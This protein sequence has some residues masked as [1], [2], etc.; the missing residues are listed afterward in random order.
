MYRPGVDFVNTILHYFL[1]IF[2]NYQFMTKRS[3]RILTEAAESAVESLKKT[4]GPRSLKRIISAGVLALNDLTAEEREYYCAL[5]A[6]EKTG[7]RPSED[8]FRRKVVQ[9]LRESQLIDKKKTT[10]RRSSSRAPL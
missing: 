8:T 3:D 6:G 9:I 2:I 10:S 1:K 5:A 4:Y 7:N